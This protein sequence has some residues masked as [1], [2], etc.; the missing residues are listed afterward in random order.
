MDAIVDAVAM[1]AVNATAA[2]THWLGSLG[3]A[4]E[5]RAAS[6]ERGPAHWLASPSASPA[7]APGV[8][9]KSAKD[10][11]APPDINSSARLPLAQVPEEDAWVRDFFAFVVA[12]ARRCAVHAAVWPET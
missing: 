12:A 9:I 11:K 5:P 2:S 1:D 10:M 3:A 6:Q 7:A 4:A 8:V